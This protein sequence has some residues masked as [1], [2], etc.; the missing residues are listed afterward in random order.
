[1]KSDGVKLVFG[2]I[3]HKFMDIN[4]VLYTFMRKPD[5]TLIH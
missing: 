4:I 1:M 5:I 3:L 2:K